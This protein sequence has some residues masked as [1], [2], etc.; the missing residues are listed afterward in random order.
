MFKHMRRKHHHH[1]GHHK[2][3]QHPT[4]MLLML[5]DEIISSGLAFEGEVYMNVK[6]SLGHSLTAAISFLDQHGNPMLSPVVPD[7]VPVWQNMDAGVEKLTS[8]ADG[9]NAT[10]EPV[11]AGVDTINVK[12]TV[13]EVLF[14][15][16]LDVEVVPEPQVLTSIAI[17]PTV[18]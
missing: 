9:M 14:T 16:T 12:V 13:G 15:A 8:S 2:H 6:L 10:A 18:S 5:G 11:A 4:Y 1:H 17:T 3:K 7:D